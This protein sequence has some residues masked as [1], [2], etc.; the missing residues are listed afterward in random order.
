MPIAQVSHWD[1]GHEALECTCHEDRCAFCE[2]GLFACVRCRSFEGATTTHCPGEL[3]TPK[4]ADDVY[5]GKLDYQ[6]G[7]WV[8]RP[9]IHSF[10]GIGRCEAI[11]Y[12]LE[13]IPTGCGTKAWWEGRRE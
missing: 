12:G 4:Q 3:I 10:A 5:D 13:P 8:D 1:D 9:S 6:D 2:G 11:A 7:M